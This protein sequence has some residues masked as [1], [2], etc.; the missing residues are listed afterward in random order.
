MHE[1]VE[2]TLETLTSL[3]RRPR[4]GMQSETDKV[5]RGE[6]AR[7]ALENDVLAE[8]FQGVQLGYVEQ[9]MNTPPSEGDTREYLHHRMAALQDVMLEL[10]GYVQIGEAADAERELREAA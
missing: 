9:L 10:H 4:R 7:A 8:A 6:R 5:A 3:L 1:F 2:A